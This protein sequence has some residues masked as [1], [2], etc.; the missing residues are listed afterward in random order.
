MTLTDAAAYLRN[1]M[2]NMDYGQTG[3]VEITI[4]RYIPPEE[5]RCKTQNRSGPSTTM[6]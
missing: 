6:V 4:T 3:H 1:V 5:D 2:R